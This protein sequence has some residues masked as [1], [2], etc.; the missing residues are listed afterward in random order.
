MKV[1]FMHLNNKRGSEYH[2]DFLELVG[3][4]FQIYFTMPSTHEN[5]FQFY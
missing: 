5:V 4:A 2:I 3:F 1:T